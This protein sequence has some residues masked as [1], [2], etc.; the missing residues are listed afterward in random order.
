MKKRMSAIFLALCLTLT[1]LPAAALADEGGET[2]VTIST[3][4]ELKTFL[5]DGKQHN[6]ET[7]CLTADLDLD[8]AELALSVRAF[9]GTF[10][11]QGHTVSNFTIDRPLF[12]GHTRVAGT[13]KNLTVEDVTLSNSENGQPRLGIVCVNH[14]GSME[15]VH[16]KDCTI[17]SDEPLGVVGGLAAM[18]QDGSA[19]EDCSVKGLTVEARGGALAVGG[20]FGLLMGNE[21]TTVKNVT[22]EDTTVKGAAKGT[23]AAKKEAGMTVG[24]L[25]GI[26][27]LGDSGDLSGNDG[28]FPD[29]TGLGAVARIGDVYFATLQAAVDAAEDGDT[30]RV[31]KDITVAK[32]DIESNTRLVKLYGGDDGCAPNLGAGT[33]LTVDLGGHTLSFAEDVAD[34]TCD[35]YRFFNVWYTN[36]TIRNGVFDLT[37][38]TTDNGICSAVCAFN[39]AVVNLNVD[40]ITSEKDQIC[41]SNGS[42]VYINGGTYTL[43]DDDYENYPY[44]GIGFYKTLLNTSA[45]TP[46]TINGGTFVNFDPLCQCKLAHYTTSGLGEGKVMFKDGGVFTVGDAADAENIFEKTVV[47]WKDWGADGTKVRTYAYATEKAAIADGA[48]A[49]IGDTYFATLQDAFNAAVDGDDILLLKDI[50][51][52]GSAITSPAAAVNGNGRYFNGGIFNVYRK[53]VTFDLNGCTITYHGHADFQWKEKTLNSC[54]YA[55]GLFMVNDGGG[56]TIRD[57][58]GTGTVIVYGMAS[59]VYACA[60]DSVAAVTG[61]TWINEGCADCGGTNLFLYASHGGELS[62]IGG[63]FEQALDGEGNSYLIVEHGGEYKNNVIDYSKTEIEI[64]GGTFVGL[65]PKEAIAVFQSA[66]NQESWGVTDVVAEGC[67]VK[68][69]T[70]A[71]GAVA[72]TV[73]AHNKTLAS[74]D[75]KL[76]TYTEKG[77]RTYYCAHCGKISH[78]EEID[79]LLPVS[80]TFAVTP[81]GAQTVV[82]DSAGNTISAETD[83]TYALHDGESYAWQTYMAGYVTAQGSFTAAE[84]L[85][86]TVSLTR[87]VTRDE[88]EDY[89]PTYTITVED[90]KNGAVT[91]SAKRAE[92]DERITLTVTLDAGYE[93]ESLTVYDAK[94]N[95]VELSDKGSGK[96]TFKMPASKVM[97]EAEFMLTKAPEEPEISVELRDVPT[98]TDVPA[99]SAYVAAVTWAAENSI[100][101][102][103]GGGIFGV[104]FPCTRGQ[105]VTFLWRALGC[106]EPEGTSWFTDVAPGSYCEKAVSWAVEQG[107]TN[108]VAVSRFAPEDPCTRAQAV[109]FL[110]RAFG[111][112]PI[113]TGGFVDVPDGAYYAQAVAWA[114]ENGVTNGIGN[115]QFGPD[116][117][118]TRAQI[119]TFLYRLLGE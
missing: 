119:V 69:S 114:V 112:S 118:C 40:F 82:K 109:T 29:V 51:V 75:T 21:S 101:D 23:N 68:Q 84:G 60:P 54:S 86:V 83:G 70:R 111:S 57:S 49:R 81:N 94:G 73:A 99:G 43:T 110:Y 104:D 2:A 52:D 85:V 7:F 17:I 116:A 88:Y 90:T 103:M 55:H 35:D 27:Y 62:I 92:Q 37:T 45:G 12:G 44:V 11:G 36:L 74:T 66:D 4:E 8:G 13:V 89:A 14:N 64:S 93:L 56:L 117:V 113:S 22:A 19:A 48:V 24:A 5:V 87:E 61:G 15:N 50:E 9:G 71:D 95:E 10:D 46:F 30:V 25:W 96:F 72:Y 53:T 108:G 115:G 100:T 67:C 41:F 20:A 105:I 32:A 34:T 58:E 97:V 38:D 26:D 102:G 106:P 63:T 18:T 42:H 47:C 76:P 3:A 39:G 77:E 107:I 31:L 98:F 78:T 79:K 59:G 6:G 91:A 1:L 33:S 65:D 80:V 16:V 28:E